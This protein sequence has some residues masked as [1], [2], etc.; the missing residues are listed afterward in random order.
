MWG[1]FL[2]ALG[3]VG[4]SPVPFIAELIGTT[5]PALKLLIS[6]LMAYPLAIIYHKFIRHQMDLRNLYYIVTGLDIAFYNF[7]LTLYHNAI[8]VFIMYLTTLVLGPGKINAI[9]SFFLIWR[10]SSLDIL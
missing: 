7:G 1:L 5:E 2:S 10:T 3:W 4:L 6:I 8:P 9:V